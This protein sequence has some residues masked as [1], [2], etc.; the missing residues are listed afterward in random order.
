MQ[1]KYQEAS[2][3]LPTQDQVIKRMTHELNQLYDV[4]EKMMEIVKECSEQLKSIALRPNPLSL[5]EHIDMMIK[6]E[7]MEKRR[8]FQK[9]IQVL[10]EF[11]QRAKISASATSFTKDPK[12]REESE[13]DVTSVMS[14]WT[15]WF[16]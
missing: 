5:T 13:K 7:E 8:D 1:K 6:A 14:R 9:R 16:V 4:V 12:Q 11:K 2:G 10:K 3:K 15:V